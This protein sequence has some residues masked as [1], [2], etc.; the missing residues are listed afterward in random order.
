VIPD[1]PDIAARKI[2]QLL[3]YVLPIQRLQIAG[4]Q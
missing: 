2:L 3:G 1:G 4:A